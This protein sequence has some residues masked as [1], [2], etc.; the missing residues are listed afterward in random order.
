MPGH[1]GRKTA[2]LP[3]NPGLPYQAA[4]RLVKVRERARPRRGLTSRSL[5]MR[6]GT[7]VDSRP[8]RSASRR[9]KAR[10]FHRIA[11]VAEV[12][13]RRVGGLDVHRREDIVPRVLKGYPIN[14]T[15][16]SVYFNREKKDIAFDNC[17]EKVMRFL[18]K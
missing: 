2:D 14:V 3:E 9:R 8:G 13:R 16:W 10:P 5:G 12:F 7:R 11:N 1:P 15:R 4:R 17:N 18:L 6:D